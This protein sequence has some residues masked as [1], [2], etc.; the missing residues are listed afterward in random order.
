MYVRLLQ[1]PSALLA[2]A[3]GFI[4]LFRSVHAFTCVYCVYVLQDRENPKYKHKAFADIHS[5]TEKTNTERLKTNDR[6]KNN[7]ERPEA[8]Q[9]E[10]E[11]KIEKWRKK[12]QCGASVEFGGTFVSLVIT[13]RSFAFH[14]YGVCYVLYT[15]YIYTMNKL[16]VRVSVWVLVCA[17]RYA[18]YSKQIALHHYLLV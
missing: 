3:D 4:N 17:L 1:L 16:V 2:M 11:K 13:I 9:T 6:A 5:K 8:R 12:T 10:E 18:I 14:S 15:C 7:D